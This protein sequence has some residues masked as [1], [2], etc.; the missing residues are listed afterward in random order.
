MKGDSLGDRM[1]SYYEGVSKQKL[2]RRIPVIMRLDA[3]AF[4]TFTKGCEKP[5]DSNIIQSMQHTTEV[6]L[7]NIQGA[8]VAY[9]QSDEISILITDYDN[10]ETCGWFDYSIQKMC[11][12]AASMAGV[13]FSIAYSLFKELDDIK[14]AY[15]D[16]RVFNI[17]KE[18]TI[19]CFRWRYQ[20]CVRNSIQ[21]VAQANFSHKELQG[22]GCKDIKTKLETEKNIRWDE[23]ANVYKNGT[24]FY[25]ETLDDGMKRLVQ[26]SQVNLNSNE[27]CAKIFNQFL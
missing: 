26:T 17:P 19:N 21:M 1:K 12:V 3:K 2:Y 13:T 15:F 23:L 4:H 24:L 18:D 5:F 16:C 11:S 6:L 10:L 22:V 8:K 27:E 25:W 20:D 7:R 14:P 9:V